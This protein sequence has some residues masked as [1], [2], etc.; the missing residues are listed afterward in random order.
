[1][2]FL[3]DTCALSELTRP[4]PHS[5]FVAWFDSQPS[6]SLFASALTVGEIEKGISLAPAGR[7]KLA[8]ETWLGR[9]RGVFAGRILHIDDAVATTWGRL[10]AAAER[11]GRPLAAI[12][13]LI[14]AT[15]L[16]HAFP[17]VTRNV[18]DYEG[19]GA[20]LIN[21]WLD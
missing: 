12:D 13:G 15:A 19:T 5:G 9:M 17:I 21:P 7:K 14:A 16:T 20:T 6:E 10:A 18:A 8:L 11:S 3:L 4:R 1:V 2:S